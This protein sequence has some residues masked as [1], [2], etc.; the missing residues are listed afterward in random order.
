M[1]ENFATLWE[2]L[3]DVLPEH[4]AIVVGDRRITWRELDDRAARLAAALAEQGVARN[5]KVALYLY[6]CPE[7][8]ECVY[9]SFKVQ[10]VPVNVNYRYLDEELS[11][12]HI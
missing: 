5:D 9:A 8:L 12:I 4:E 7:Y 2:S 10:A 1:D 6:N 3:A 11:L